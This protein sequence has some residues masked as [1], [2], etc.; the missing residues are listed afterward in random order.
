MGLDIAVSG[1]LMTG[2]GYLLIDLDDRMLEERSN[3][4]KHA[5]MNVS[6]VELPCDSD[7]E[8]DGTLPYPNVLSH[9]SLIHI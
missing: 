8:A 9:L 7:N 4:W 3:R 1:V 6:N 5:T 2:Y